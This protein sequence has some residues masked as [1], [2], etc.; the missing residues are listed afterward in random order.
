MAKK[1]GIIAGIAVAAV[2]GIAAVLFISQQAP[3]VLEED[4]TGA[5]GAAERYRAEQIT[6]ADVE[7][8]GE[9]A[10]NAAVSEAAFTVTGEELVD[11]LG[12]AS[13]QEKAAYF[14]RA[15][16]DERVSMVAR[17][18]VD[19]RAAALQRATEAE[20]AS[21]LERASEAEKAAAL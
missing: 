6:D 14:E 16:V 9:I 2:V 17:L 12:K 4:A 21:A 5:I 7:L 18:S 3:T 1:N 15:S 20:K 8:D 11:L 10:G 13:V 19:E